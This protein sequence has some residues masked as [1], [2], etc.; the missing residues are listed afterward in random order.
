M[1]FKG[2]GMRTPR[3]RALELGTAVAGFEG[4]PDASTYNAQAG[5]PTNMVGGTYKHE[6]TNLYNNVPSKSKKAP[7]KATK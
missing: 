7:F 5:C 6:D 1:P 3:T 4:A 2:P